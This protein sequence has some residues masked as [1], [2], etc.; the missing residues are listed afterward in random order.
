MVD[1]HLVSY[2][3]DLIGDDIACWSMHYLC[4]LS[5]DE[6]QIALHQ[7]AYYWPFE[8]S[9]TVTVWLQSMTRGRI[10]G[11]IRCSMRPRLVYS[12]TG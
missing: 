4:K 10:E 11:I 12:A 1:S 3:R 5:H 2:V 6:K 7:D 8:K 9:R